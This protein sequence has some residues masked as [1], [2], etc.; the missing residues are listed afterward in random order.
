MKKLEWIRTEYFAHRG[1]H[2]KNIPENTIG[3]FKN[4]VKNGFHIELDV[5]LTKDDKIVVFH[6]EN[7]KRLCM[8]DA[9]LES[10][11]FGDLGNFPILKTNESIPLLKTVLDSMPKET[12]YLIE[13]KSSKNPRMFVSLFLNLLKDYNITYAIHSFDPRIL[14]QFK[15]QDNNV[16]R[17][18]ISSRFKNKKGL[19]Y[20]F[21]RHMSLNWLTKPDFINYNFED[22]PQ[23]H[24][25]KLYNK[26]EIIISYVAKNQKNLDFVRDRYDNAVFEDFIPKNKG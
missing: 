17:G 5:R 2:N 14:Y 13:L 19:H 12:M 26:G 18:Q 23:K 4:A 9:K 20:I 16:I 10:L 24:L 1:L 25:D 11:N 6:D 8:I 22:L 7:L 3:A 21:A 15:K